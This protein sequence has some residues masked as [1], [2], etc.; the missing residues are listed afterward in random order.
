MIKK[1][2]IFIT[3][4]LVIVCV[5]QSLLLDSTTSDPLRTEATYAYLMATADQTFSSAAFAPTQTATPSN[6]FAGN[7]QISGN[8][9]FSKNYG[10]TT[11]F[12]SGY[13]VWPAFDYEFVQDKNRLIPVDR[14]HGFIGSGA[15]SITAG[16]GSVWDEVDDNKKKEMAHRMAVY[17]AQIDCVDQNIGKMV[18]YLKKTDQFD[19]KTGHHRA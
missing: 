11:D 6:T 3:S 9:V 1:L 16:V 2:S 10:V 15:W 19:N 5:Y 7:L 4:L 8:P 13:S 17:A 18:E 14:G 12:P